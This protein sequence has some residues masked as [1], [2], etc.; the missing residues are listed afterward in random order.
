M[1]Q[2]LILR[3]IIISMELIYSSLGSSHS[4]TKQIRVPFFKYLIKQA[5]SVYIIDNI[6]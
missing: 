1:H 4:M 5:I 6:L 3:Q 2:F